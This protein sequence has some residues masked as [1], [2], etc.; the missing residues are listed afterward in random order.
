MYD[1][2][3]QPQDDL[4]KAS[5]WNLIFMKRTNRLAMSMFVAGIVYYIITRLILKSYP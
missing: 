2:P 5:R 4:P 1:E 3:K